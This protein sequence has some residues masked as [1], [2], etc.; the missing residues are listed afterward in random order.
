MSDEAAPPPTLDDLMETAYDRLELC[1]DWGID[2]GLEKI[3]IERAMTEGNSAR[4]EK[5]IARVK[6]KLQKC[7]A[8]IFGAYNIIIF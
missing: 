4:L 3:M 8:A 7:D 1:R 5:H 6:A 2:I